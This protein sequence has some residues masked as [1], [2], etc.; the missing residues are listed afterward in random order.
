MLQIFF[1]I[2]KSN[3]VVTVRR[4]R[5]RCGYMLIKHILMIISLRKVTEAFFSVLKY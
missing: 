4:N 2:L 3:V 1:K 5:N